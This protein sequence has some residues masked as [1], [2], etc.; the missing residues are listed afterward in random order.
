MLVI[1]RILFVAVL[2]T[3]AVGAAGCRE[4]K[5]RHHDS[6]WHRISVIDRDPDD[7]H[8]AAVHAG[9]PTRPRGHKGGHP[10]HGR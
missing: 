5:L 4:H 7:S 8:R 6:R 9:R 10:R 2:G 1:A 3:V